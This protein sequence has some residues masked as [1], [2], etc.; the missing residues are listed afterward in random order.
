MRY[1]KIFLSLCLTMTLLGCGNKKTDPNTLIVGTMAGPESEIVTVA[2][3]IA[4]NRYGL[5]IKI[6]EFSDYNLPNA[7]LQDGTLDVNI[8]QHQPYLDDAIRAQHYTLESVGKTFLYPMAIYSNKIKSLTELRPGAVIA[9][10]NDP[11]N[12]ARALLL[13]QD[14]NLIQL[15]KKN[16]S[17]LFDIRSNPNHYQFRELDAAQLSRVLPDVDI[18]VI[19]TNFAIPAGLHPNRNGLFMEKKTSPYANLIV[20]RKNNG[21]NEQIKHFV[22]ALHSPEVTTKAQ[23]VFSDAAIPAW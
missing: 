1:L 9:I 8:F 10:P 13:L 11:S 15:K 6:I 14:A 4:Q 3:N 21:K 19:N 7:A 18:A 20:V 16:S 5:T 22:E 17:A 2:Q 12:E 23:E